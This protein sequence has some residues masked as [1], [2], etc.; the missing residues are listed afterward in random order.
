MEFERV[1]AIGDCHGMAKMLINLI[2]QV[3]KFKP[4]TDKLVLLGDYLERG[5]SSKGVVLYLDA[6]KKR[7]PENIV[8]LLGNH[9][10]KAYESLKSTRTTGAI[11]DMR[12]PLSWILLDGGNE[13]IEEFGG[14]EPMRQILIPFIESLDVYHEDRNHIFVHGGVPKDMTDI[15]NV[16]IEDLLWN[17]S[18]DY[19]GDKTI[20]VGHSVVREVQQINKIIFCDTGACFTGKLSAFDIINRRVYWIEDKPA[21]Q[22]R[23]N[24]RMAA[25]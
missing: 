22:W 16:P 18:M 13:T 3:I 2:E 23:S 8:L 7:Y 1:I 20:V 4:D 17:R 25:K 5:P 24:G 15:R 9:E 21:K 19:E 12:E 11:E 6:L 14:L 10:M